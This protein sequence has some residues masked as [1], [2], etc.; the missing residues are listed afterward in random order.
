[1]GRRLPGRSALAP[2][3]DR[4]PGLPLLLLPEPLTH[5]GPNAAAQ[6]TA[7]AQPCYRAL[8]DSEPSCAWLLLSRRVNLS[9]LKSTGRSNLY[10]GTLGDCRTVPLP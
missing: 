1:M 2:L 9:T 8:A 4:T 10:L 6:R 5:P 7:Y 3:A